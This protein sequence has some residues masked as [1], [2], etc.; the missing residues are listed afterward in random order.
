MKMKMITLLLIVFEM[1]C[2]LGMKTKYQSTFLKE[3]KGDVKGVLAKGKLELSKRPYKVNQCDQVILFKGSRI[4]NFDDYSKQKSSH[5]SLSAYLLN[6]FEEKNPNKLIDSIN[7]NQLLKEPTNLVGMKKC[8]NFTAQSGRIAV[9]LGNEEEAEEV[10]KAYEEFRSC[11]KGK[12]ESPCEKEIQ[13]RLEEM[14][15]NKGTNTTMKDS[16]PINQQYVD[17]NQVDYYGMNLKVPGSNITVNLTKEE[18]QRR[19]RMENL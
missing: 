3:D 15:L 14:K 12:K 2:I 9:C 16:T 8:I 5:F 17:T 7:I 19:K 4:V 13:K 10:L 6:V 11:V 18:Y 1:V